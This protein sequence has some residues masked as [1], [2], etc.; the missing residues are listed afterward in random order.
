MMM[1][2]SDWGEVQSRMDENEDV[3]RTDD[4]YHLYISQ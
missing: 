4:L 2:R 3:I 1:I